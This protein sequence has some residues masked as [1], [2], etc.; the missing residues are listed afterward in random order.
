MEP[1][2]IMEAYLSLKDMEFL[3]YVNKLEE[4]DELEQFLAGDT[5]ILALRDQN[6]EAARC[7]LSKPI[8]VNAYEED[9]GATPLMLSYDGE[10]DLVKMLLDKGADINAAD[11]QGMSPLMHA[12]K[13]GM[14]EVAYFLIQQGADVNLPSDDGSTPLMQMAYN[15]FE[16]DHEEEERDKIFMQ[17]LVLM[18]NSGAEIDAKSNDGDTAL[19]CSL[20]T[21]MDKRIVKLLL[22]RGADTNVEND[23]GETPLNLAVQRNHHEVLNDLLSFGTDINYK[24]TK[25]MTALDYAESLTDRRCYNILKEWNEK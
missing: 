6:F 16:M 11:Y 3:S 1:K 13:W 15:S 10:L 2:N 18:I 22:E 9:R 24:N 19:L 14:F 12:I 23:I 7:L 25:N 20:E 17:T 8:N 4:L 5:L 21:Q